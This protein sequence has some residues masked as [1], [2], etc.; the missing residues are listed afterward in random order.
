MLPDIKKLPFINCS[1][2]ANLVQ[3]LISI[4]YLPNFYKLNLYGSE[5]N[6]VKTK[7]ESR[8]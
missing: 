3:L 1:N 4:K 8:V 7:Q 5:N 2:D 6:E